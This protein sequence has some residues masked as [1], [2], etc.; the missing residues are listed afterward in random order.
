MQQGIGNFMNCM[1]QASLEAALINGVGSYQ[2]RDVQPMGGDVWLLVS[3]LQKSIRRGDIDV[4]LGAA[5]TLLQI[6][7]RR[8]WQRLHIIALE[9][10]GVGGINAVLQVLMATA[11]P[12]MRRKLCEV[13]TG[14]YLTDL[15]C[16]ATK[17]RLADAVCII[18]QHAT[19]RIGFREECGG[20]SN[21]ELT[22]IATNEHADIIPR[23][24][25]AWYLA[26]TKRYPSDQLVSREGDLVAGEAMLRSIGVPVSLLEGCIGVLKR[27]PYPLAL[28]MPFI[29]LEAQKHASQFTVHEHHLPKAPNVNGL[30]LYA[31]DGFT[32]IGRRCF[33]AL[34]NQ[35]HALKHY[36]IAQIA[37]AVFYEEGGLVNKQLC[38]PSLDLLQREGEYV[39]VQSAGLGASAYDALREIINEQM[40][41]LQAIREKLL[42]S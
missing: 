28:H 5:Q 23:A 17:S 27:T 39:D 11:K 12:D 41:L 1:D 19:S 2:L 32:R 37:L 29:C 30:P 35:V 15:L 18:S 10:V 40:R 21:K 13:Q 22:D 24:I 6:D 3:A 14:L 33:A 16:H 7:K 4:A 36:S 26:G 34:K 9:D 31:A 8:F 25:A 42:C 38:A 20:Y